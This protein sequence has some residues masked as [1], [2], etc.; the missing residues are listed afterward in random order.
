MLI[1]KVWVS[2]LV[3]MF[4]PTLVER[5]K[6]KLSIKGILMVVRV[7]SIVEVRMFV[8][9]KAVLLNAE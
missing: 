6:S 7:D 1:K 3:I 2:K 8:K 5:K 9:C 4:K